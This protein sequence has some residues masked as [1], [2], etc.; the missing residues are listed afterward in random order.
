M[1]E[2]IS[3]EFH[4]LKTSLDPW[5]AY[6]AYRPGQEEMLLRAAN[7]CKMG[8]VM[9]IDA[10]T[11][12]GKSSIVSSMLAKANGRLVIVA[13][14]TISQLNTFVR[15]L[16]LIRKKQPELKYSYLIGKGSSCPLG[17]EGDIYRKCE[18]VKALSISL[19]KERAERGHLNPMEDPFIKQQIRKNEEE[20]PI[21]CPYF[22]RSKTF[23]RSDKTQTLRLTASEAVRRKGDIMTSQSIDPKFLLGMCE[24]LCPYEVMMQAASKSDVLILNY[25]HL[26]DAGIYEQLCTLLERDP[27]D[28]LLLID[29]AHNCGEVMQ[30]I[31]S[32]EL[33]EIVLD[34][35]E[36]EIAGLRKDIQNLDAIRHLLP[37]IKRFIDGLRRS[38]E[39]EDWFDPAL[40]SR[41]I[42][43]ESFF[44]SIDEVASELLSVAE[45]LAEK[46][47]KS[48]DYRI[49]GLE[50]LSLF[51]EKIS[52]SLK[53]SSYLTIYRK[54]GEKIVLHVRNI[55]PAP[56]LSEIARY[57][58][59]TIMVSGTLTPLESYRQLYLRELD[60]KSI[61]LLSLSNAFPKENRKLLGCE[62]ITTAYKMRQE[63]SNTTLI[64]EYIVQFSS[65]PGNLAVYFPS[66][67]LLETFAQATESR[68]E[69]KE[70][71]IEPR[72]ASEA[73][74]LHATF[75]GL[76][77]KNREGILF[78][79][80]GGKFSEGLDYRGDM[81]SGAMV[82]GLPLA[83]YNNVRRMIMD[84]YKKRYGNAGEFLSYTLPALNKGLQ[85]LGR[86]LRTPED[87]GV[88]VFADKRFLEPEI[89][90]TIPQWMQD[91]LVLVN[92]D[93]FPNHTI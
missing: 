3:D 18:V 88:L 16:A 68:I 78:A 37:G 83:P 39:S 62:D 9:L 23:A 54:E 1:T 84:Y 65:L 80:C 24:N 55:D 70:V 47:Q 57:H 77:M 46:K 15:E 40:F 60:T 58:Y 19:L 14:R 50:L 43:K 42:L 56:A 36:R 51:F 35:A 86:V 75:T 5:F 20:H 25:Y 52:R 17:G 67:L 53:H 13:V 26:F 87:S 93:S 44:T 41:I 38:K 59:A 28:I 72:D 33:S 31:L 90:S 64:E 32:V 89:F 74:I 81:L 48:G 69:H 11:G 4:E 21:I 12:S 30:E 76:P 49:G 2:Q 8:G 66:Y 82:V 7:V 10:P 6:P 91:E 27:S 71:F 61:S 22:I 73:S 63:K 92:I 34:N 85:S 29:E 79:V 45:A